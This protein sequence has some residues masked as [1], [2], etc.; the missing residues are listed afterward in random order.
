MIRIPRDI[1]AKHLISKL[2]KLGYEV[3][4]QKGSH[5]TLKRSGQNEHT[6]FIPNHNPI[7]MGTLNSILKQVAAANGMTIADLMQELEL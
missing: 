7:R 1:G 3:C 4:R 5:I 2:S 6:V